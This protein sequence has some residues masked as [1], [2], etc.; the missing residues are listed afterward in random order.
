MSDTISINPKTAYAGVQEH[1]GSAAKDSGDTEYG[2]KVASAFGYSE[3][4]LADAPAESNLGLSCG[5]PFAIANLRQGET[6]IDLGSGAGFDVFQAAK[7]VAP[8]GKVIGVDMNQDM[9]QRANSIKQKIKADNTSFVESSLTSISLPDAT[10][11]CIISNCVINL[12]PEPEKHLAYSE[13]F[14]SLK[15]KGRVAISDI[16]LKQDMPSELKNDMALYVGCI[17]GAS[18]LEQCERYLSDAGFKDTLIVADHSDLNIYKTASKDNAGLGCCGP[19]SKGASS[20]GGGN[21][22]EKVVEKR[23]DI[24]LNEWAGK[25][26]LFVEY[27]A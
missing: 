23:N 26:L 13:M 16:L 18:R 11:D 2:R 9:L 7:K 5:N 12:V 1:Y 20:C 6:V 10:A 4:E 22:G 8:S 14:R 25:H 15:P 17:S 19:A 3:E 24:D 27:I 21:G